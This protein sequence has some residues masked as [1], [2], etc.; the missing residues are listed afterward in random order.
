MIVPRRSFRFCSVLVPGRLL[1]A[2]TFFPGFFPGGC[3][4]FGLVAHLRGSTDATPHA[5]A[6]GFRAGFYNGF[7][8]IFVV[9]LA[10]P[11]IRRN[12]SGQKM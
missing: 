2:T 9:F 8:A 10:I 12:A 3:T 11:P 5:F 6:R 1:R 7:L 4:R